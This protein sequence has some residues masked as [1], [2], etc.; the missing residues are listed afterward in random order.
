MKRTIFD[1]L[2]YIL[3]IFFVAA[4]GLVLFAL[5]RASYSSTFSQMVVLV[6][7]ILLTIVLVIQ[8]IRKFHSQ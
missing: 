2:E 3:A 1:Q 5:L 6:A 8:F 4:I 7:T